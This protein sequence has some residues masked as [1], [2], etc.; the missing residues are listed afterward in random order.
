MDQWFHLLIIII[1]ALFLWSRFKPA[2]GVNQISMK[3]LKEIVQRKPKS[4]QFV[5]VRTPAEFNGN[6]MKGFMNIPL[7]Q[8]NNQIANLNKDQEV[9][10]ICQSGMRSSNASKILKKHG[11]AHITNV[12]GGMS[13]W[14]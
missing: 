7:D 9:I 2:V 11:F 10:V 1:I 13:A 12:K 8:L 3:D 14:R 6:H 4:V 5:D